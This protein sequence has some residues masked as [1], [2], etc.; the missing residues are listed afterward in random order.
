MREIINICY[1]TDSNYFVPTLTSIMSVAENCKNSEVN[2]YVVCSDIKQRY[3]SILENIK[4]EN[5]RIFIKKLDNPYLDLGTKH[6]H[7]SKTALLKFLLPEIFSDLDKILYLDGDILVYKDLAE[8][9]QTDLHEYYAA[10]VSDMRA[11]LRNKSNVS[12]R[13]GNYFNSG[14]MLLN[15]KKM[16]EDNLTQKLSELKQNE[17]FQR[18][19][20]QDVLN[21]GFEENV[22][23]IVPK[24]NF[25]YECFS[26]YKY[27]QIAQYYG[28]TD[29]QVKDM[30][31]KPSVLHLTNYRKPW[32]SFLCPCFNKWFYYFLKISDFELKAKTIS[33][34]V[35]ATGKTEFR[36]W[37]IQIKRIIERIIWFLA[38]IEI[39]RF[40]ADIKMKLNKNL[41]LNTVSRNKKIIISLTTFPERIK[42]LKY[43]LYSLFNQTVKADKIVLY[44]SEEE[45]KNKENDLPEDIKQFE[46]YGL[47]IRWVKNLRSY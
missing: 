5:C 21:K 13:L 25:Q 41:S 19:M 44:L 16:R 24:Y 42:E 35:K 8:L 30:Y 6:R 12:L 14:V 15:L 36:F 23:F 28:I 47:E 1:I 29:E 38:P 3:L 45:F 31:K 26:D 39:N 18:F 9:Y 7:V 34:I 2:I 32:N 20:D 33:D 43:V 17:E 22:I 40:F 46:N 10:A 4:F 27:G 11:V 37:A